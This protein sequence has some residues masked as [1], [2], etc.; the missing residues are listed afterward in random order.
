MSPQRSV[1]TEVPGG[2]ANGGGVWQWLAG[3]S[4]PLFVFT[5]KFVEWWY[6][7]EKREAVRRLTVLPVPPPPSKMKVM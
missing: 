1:D 3:N 7:A 2:V 6:S 5:L 4:F